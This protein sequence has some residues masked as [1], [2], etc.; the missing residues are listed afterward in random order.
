MRVYGNRVSKQGGARRLR[1]KTPLKYNPDQPA[2]ASGQ[3]RSETHDIIWRS[4]L[5]EAAWAFCGAGV[6]VALTYT[7]LFSR[8][9]PQ[10]VPFMDR[11]PQPVVAWGNELIPASV[12]ASRKDGK[13][14][15]IEN[16]NGDEAI[17][18]LP[19]AFRAEDY[20]FIKVNLSG[21]TRYS[22]FKILWRQADN[23][24]KTHALEFNRS[25][26]EVTQI[27][28][29]YGGDNYRGLISDI[30]LLF[31]DGPALAFENNNSVDIV[32]QNIEFLPFSAARVVEQIFEDWTNPP[33]WRGISNNTVKYVHEA[34]IISTNIVAHILLTTS[35]MFSLI[36]R[37][38]TGFGWIHIQP[39]PLLK[40]SVLLCLFCFLLADMCRWQW[41]IEQ[42][43]DS[44]DRYERQALPQ[45]ISKNTIRC[46]RD[47]ADCYEELLPYF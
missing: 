28:M 11:A 39:P 47:P 12:G 18:V 16:F 33:L 34:S 24:E 4:S 15:I 40:T 31:Y 23:P 43:Q 44:R 32:I 20:P 42:W 22:K 3:T 1:T 27:A 37:G 10:F 19:R 13:S 2:E 9:H 45:N 29:V 25:N 41:R 26:D 36:F 14:T 46:A 17:L 7:L 5:K 38:L 30:A 35:F 8:I 6:L 21:F